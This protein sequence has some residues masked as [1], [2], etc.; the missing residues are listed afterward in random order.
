MSSTGTGDVVSAL[1]TPRLRSYLLAVGGDVDRALSLYDWN[2]AASAC[3][4]ADLARVEVVLRNTIDTALSDLG[5]NR[6]WPTVWYQRS[7]LFTGR[8]GRRALEDIAV[9][10]QRAT[11]GGVREVHGKVI[12]ELTFGFWRYLCTTQYLTSMWVPAL[13]SSFQSHPSKGDPRRVRADVEDRVQ[14]LWFL[15]NRIAHLEPIHHRSL[16]DD[17]RDLLELGGWISP[18]MRSWIAA[19]SRWASVRTNRP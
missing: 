16:D 15:R 12:S 10:R 18:S 13:A 4:Y 19:E 11:R 5:A 14:R 6:K 2:V 9:A 3:F 8:S 7:T 1:T 17:R